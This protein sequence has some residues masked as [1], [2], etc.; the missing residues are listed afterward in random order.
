MRFVSPLL[1]KVV[2]PTLA[3]SGVLRRISPPG[4]A[5][6]TYHGILP[7]GYKVID[8]AFDGNLI[9]AEEFERQLRHLKAN[10]N[11]VAPADLLA[12]R[13]GQSALPTRAVL[14]T[15]DDGLV[16]HLTDMLPILATENLKCLFFVLGGI[17][18]ASAKRSTTEGGG[19][20]RGMLWYEELFLLL[21]QKAQDST[22]QSPTRQSS[23]L[24]GAPAERRAYWWGEVQRLSQI[25]ADARREFLDGLRESLGRCAEPELNLANPVSCRRFALMNGDEVRQ[26]AAAG[27]T[28]GAHTLTHPILSQLSV[29]QARVEIAESRSR[30][31]SLLE[32]EVWALAYPF[33]D[34]TSVTPEVL[35]I[36]ERAGYAAA[37]LNY[38]GGLGASLAP[39]ALPRI[40][41]T[42]KMSLAELEAHISGVH[43]Q[44]QKLAS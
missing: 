24:Q 41:V 15:C 3:R 29:E 40:H 25:D 21:R 42:A 37:F 27:M 23:A 38:G 20:E 32:R 6:V 44:L 12:W 28:I 39:Y 30:L 17:T 16:N 13:K 33:G 19:E 9:R 18:G 43:G 36:A 26:L 14:L 8:A 2:Y 31:E 5:I 34:P 22:R 10:Y 35:A 11:I 7:E 1:K 4:L